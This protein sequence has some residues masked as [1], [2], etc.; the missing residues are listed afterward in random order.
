VGIRMRRVANVLH[1][2]GTGA[3][4]RWSSVSR[5]DGDGDGDAP[6][7]AVAGQSRLL[8]GTKAHDLA[9]HYASHPQRHLAVGGDAPRAPC[10]A[11]HAIA[12]LRGSHATAVCWTARRADA[13]Q[14]VLGSCCADEP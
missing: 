13:I 3:R 2:M 9:R 4:G 14:P 5:R 6:G 8:S 7:Q 12:R 10:W 1:D 11:G